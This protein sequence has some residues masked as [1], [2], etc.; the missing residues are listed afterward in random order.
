MKIAD[1]PGRLKL[2]QWPICGSYGAGVCYSWGAGGFRI[3]AG[4][5]AGVFKDKFQCSRCETNPKLKDVW[6][7]DKKTQM[8]NPTF[9]E[10]ENGMHY[11]YW[12]CPRKFIPDSIFKFLLIKNYHESFPSAPMPAF[13]DVSPRF[14]IAN[15]YYENKL[16]EYQKDLNDG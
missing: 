10:M 15:N 3:I 9:E 4:I 11:K 2:T 16:N 6:G 7:C 13:E 8:P 5:H 12:Q 14:L 1:M